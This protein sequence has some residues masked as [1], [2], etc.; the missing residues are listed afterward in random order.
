MFD[1]HKIAVSDWDHAHNPYLVEFIDAR[2]N[3]VGHFGIGMF[4]A[5]QKCV[6]KFGFAIPTEEAVNL[7]AKRAPKGVVEIGAGTGYWASLLSLVIPV[8]AYDPEPGGS[9]K[10]PYHFWKSWFP[11]NRGD[12]KR[13]LGCETDEALMLCWP[14]YKEDWSA[15]A[16]EF[17]RGKT[18]VYIGEGS[19]GCTGNDRLHELIYT[20]WEMVDDCWLPQWP[21]IHDSLE[22]YNRKS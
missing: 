10:S 16:V 6:Q 8:R 5:R 15:E 18:L 7:I 12:H 20:G 17:Y 9:F 14:D 19:G 2:K 4:Q 11:V 22:I 13:L 1:D 3:A 21:G